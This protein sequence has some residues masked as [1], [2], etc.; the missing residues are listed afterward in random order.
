MHE[1]IIAHPMPFVIH[2]S[3]HLIHGLDVF[4][5]LKAFDLL[6]VGRRSIKRHLLC[7]F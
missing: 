3:R 4:T 2:Y 7:A 6:F 1:A 5:I